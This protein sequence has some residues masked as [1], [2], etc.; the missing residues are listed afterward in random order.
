MDV[1][2]FPQSVWAE[3]LHYLTPTELVTVSIIDLRIITSRTLDPNIG[4]SKQD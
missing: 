1:P 2:E 4:D 3:N